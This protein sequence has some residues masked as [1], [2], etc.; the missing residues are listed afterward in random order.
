[1]EYIRRPVDEFAATFHRCDVCGFNVKRGRHPSGG[2]FEPPIPILGATFS[3]YGRCAAQLAGSTTALDDGADAPTQSPIE[4][5]LD[6]TAGKNLVFTVEGA[7]GSNS[8]AEG[9]TSSIV[10]VTAGDQN[11]IS[12]LTAPDLSLVGVFLTDS[13][14]SGSAPSTPDYTLEATRN[15]TT[16]SPSIAQQFYIG[17]GEYTSSDTTY[18]RQVV[19][20]ATATRLF[21]ACHTS[22]NWST[23]TGT[24][25]G[26]VNMA[27]SFSQVSEFAFG[28]KAG[29]VVLTDRCPGQG[30][31]FCGSPAWQTGGKAGD[32]KRSW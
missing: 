15:Y 5:N 19:I 22:A 8:D 16:V 26:M 32:L 23:Q 27:S 1:M 10:S 20:P 18:Y 3:V 2:E 29:A 21:V 30:C 25:H 13:A 9:D 28:N 14:A 31:P 7:F 17:E 11:S 12:D 4:V 24:I 6:L